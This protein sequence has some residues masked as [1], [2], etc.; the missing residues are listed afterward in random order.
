MI[1][2]SRHVLSPDGSVGPATLTI[3]GER[4][5]EVALGVAEPEHLVDE[6]ILPGYVDTH[7]HGAAGVGFVDPDHEAVLRAIGY[8]RSQ[9]STTL[10]AST[11]AEDMDDLVDQISRLRGLVDEGELDGIHLE[12]PFLAPSRKGAHD[13][14]LLREPSP[15]R[16]SRLIDAGGPALRMITL[17]PELRYGIEATEAIAAAGVH[18][19]FGHSEADA[20]TARDAVDAG[21]DIVT[22]LFNAMAPIHHRKPGPVPW[23]LTD[24][25]VM[26]ELICDGVHVAPDVIRMVLQAAGPERIGLVTDAMSATGQPDGDYMLGH[27]RVRVTNGGARLLNDDGTLGAI[28]GSTLTLGRAVEFL[29]TRVGVP[30][31]QAA[32]MASTTPARWHGLDAGRIEPGARADLCLTDASGHLNRVLRAGREV[33]R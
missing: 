7:C 12:G 11:V 31:A 24:P 13:L 26:C 5:S 32:T 3:D 2:S 8:H 22:H 6:W 33:P 29:V 18:A 21:A 14:S 15:S 20:A 30:L 16:V 25:R 27:L 19:A 10:F 4:I 28:A 23:M 9:G 17:A 1:I